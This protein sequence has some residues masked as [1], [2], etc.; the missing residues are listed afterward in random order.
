MTFSKNNL[1]E[2]DND[3]PIENY[4]ELHL[5]K[6]PEILVEMNIALPKIREKSLYFSK[7]GGHEG[8]GNFSKF[9]LK[10]LK[11]EI[12]FL[13][14]SSQN[15]CKFIVTYRGLFHSKNPLTMFIATR[16]VAGGDLLTVLNVSSPLSCEQ[17]LT[18]LRCLSSALMFV[19]TNKVRN[20]NDLPIFFG[21]T[22][23]I[24]CG[25]NEIF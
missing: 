22:N 14:L 5:T 19:H 2:N 3:K 9:Q 23:F 25:R 1:T 6:V 8:G 4:Y 18:V 20:L 21:L 10:M 12:E 13:K 7:R 24:V 16:L 17:C 15:D 11:R